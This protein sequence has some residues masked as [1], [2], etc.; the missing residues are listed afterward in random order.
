MTGCI[1]FF[2]GVQLASDP[3]LDFGLTTVPEIMD[4][5]DDDGD[6][7]WPEFLDLTEMLYQRRAAPGALR[8]A[9]ERSPIVLW[10]Q[11]YRKI[12]LKNLNQKA[13]VSM[14]N[15]LLRKIATTDA[16]ASKYLIPVFGVMKASP[17]ARIPTSG[18][19]ML[20]EHIVGERHVLVLDPVGKSHGLF[21]ERGKRR[22]DARFVTLVAKIDVP[23]VLDMVRLTDDRFDVFDVMPL[24]DFKAGR[25]LMPQKDRH[26]VLCGMLGLFQTVCPA[27]HVVPKLSLDLATKEGKVALTALHFPFYLK[28]PKSIYEAKLSRAWRKVEAQ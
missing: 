10:N 6:F 27:L 14:I 8:R 28:D 4:A 1:P 16:E 13:A 7:E 12:L 24:R 23:I 15:R 9:A 17:I 5:E 25:C 19:W 22:Q 11:F 26:A 2:K 20:D 3:F 18:E 21:D